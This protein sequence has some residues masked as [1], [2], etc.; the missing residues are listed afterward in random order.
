[1]VAWKTLLVGFMAGVLAGLAVWGAGL[2][3]AANRGITLYIDS[4]EIARAVQ[5][6]VT[7]FSQEQFP[8]Y[9]EEARQEIPGVVEE[10]VRGQFTYGSLEIAGFSFA[11]PGEFIQGL[12]DML[13]ENIQGGINEII[14]GIDS[15]ALGEEMGTQAYHMVKNALEEEYRGKSFEVWPLEWFSLLV[16]LEIK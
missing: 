6:Q 16:N 13:K 11:L 14:D 10:Q 5:Q 12:E 2:H 7:G 1:M 4:E 8:R 3:Y 15:K 9:L